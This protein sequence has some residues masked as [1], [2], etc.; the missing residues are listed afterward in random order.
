MPPAGGT[1]LQAYVFTDRAIARALEGAFRRNLEVIVLFDKG[2]RHEPSSVAPEL[3]QAGLEVMVDDRPRIAH[4][5]TIII[6]PDGPDP[7][8]ETGSFNFSYSA[9]HRNAEN[10]L[11]VRDD[12]AL[13]AVYERSPRNDWLSPTRGDWSSPARW[14]GV[15]TTAV[16]N[17]LQ[18][19]STISLGL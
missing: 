7:V 1:H 19:Q 3:M 5:K 4:N 11:L 2:Q 13:A 14:P 9:E 16:R 6:D 18:I 10:A 8:V 17:N 15:T 12:P